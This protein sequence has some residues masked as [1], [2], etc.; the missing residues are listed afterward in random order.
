MW[1]PFLAWD[2]QKQVNLAWTNPCCKQLSIPQEDI[3][4]TLSKIKSYMFPQ[5]ICLLLQLDVRVFKF[6]EPRAM[7]ST[8]FLVSLEQASLM[9]HTVKNLPA[10]Q[11]TQA[12]SLSQED[13]LEEEMAT[14]SSI[15]A[16]RNPEDRGAWQAIVH[17]VEK[18]WTWLRD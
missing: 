10:M 12:W 6:F 16:W 4:L 1:K 15:F 2:R 11:D 3:K 8:F 13:C 18:R 9:A 7:F 5:Y 17:G 14:H